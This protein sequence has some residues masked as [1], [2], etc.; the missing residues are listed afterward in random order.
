[1]P[2]K[3]VTGKPAQKLA[4]EIPGSIIARLRT[5]R[6]EGVIC[7]ALADRTSCRMLYAAMADGREYDTA[8]GG[9]I[10]AFAAG[11]PGGDLPARIA[12]SRVRRLSVEQSNT[13][14]VLDD[15]YILKFF[16][17]LEDGP[18]P[19]LEI[20]L[21]LTERTEYRGMPQ[22]QGGMAYQ[23]AGGTE[24][25][26]AMLQ[27]FIA[28]DGDG[29]THGLQAARDFLAALRRR[30]WRQAPS[31]LAA[32]GPL[33][34][35][36]AEPPE[37]FTAAAGEFPAR[38]AELGRRTALFH[39]ALAGDRRRRSDFTPQ[40]MTTADLEVLADGC[41]RRVR[42]VLEHL[43]GR[44]GTLSDAE[45]TLAD[46]VLAAGPGLLAR[47][48]QLPDLHDAG[49]LIRIHG[50]YHL[51]QVL[52]TESGWL[53]LD[54][55]G[56]P[57][58]PLAERRERQSPLKDVAG[59]I[60]SFDYAAQTVRH[61]LTE[62]WPRRSEPVAAWSAVW[63]RW[64]AAAFVAGY[65]EAMDDRLPLA[66]GSA[67]REALLDAF[68]LDKAFYELYYELNNR[69][70]WVHIPLMGILDVVAWAAGPENGVGNG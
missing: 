62:Q 33:Q 48:Q 10:R 19:D 15:T 54:F 17:Q 61:E 38:V 32:A 27:D 47:F 56:E 67:A 3:A 57:L 68:L 42:E 6:A 12:A 26:V 34:L 40:A 35:A 51:G 53:L 25:T 4:A 60:R 22:V 69:P 50:D 44:M 41:A 16:R 37:N 1:L 24:T 8:R 21:Y 39:R 5:P 52:A 29:W 49:Q 59:M 2:L 30:R 36:R 65:L 23:S 11:G 28:N 58:R 13:S 31:A 43:N 14:I 45:R 46:R 7:D 64:T 63:S 70:D 66:T 9:R 18:N 55:E 20:G